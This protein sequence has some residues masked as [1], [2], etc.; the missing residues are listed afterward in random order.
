MRAQIVSALGA[1]TVGL[2]GPHALARSYNPDLSAFYKPPATSGQAG[3]ADVSAFKEWAA[4]LGLATAPKFLG[5]ASTLGSMGFEV[6]LEVGLTTIHSGR[7]YWKKAASDPGNLLVTNQVRI[8]KGLPYSLQISGLVTH[9]LDSD[10]WGIGLEV[11]WAAVEGF[12]YVP[13]IAFQ[14][15]VGTLLGSGDLAMLQVGFGA[16]LSK[17]FN[18]AGLFTVAPYAGYHLLFFNA[19][20]YLTAGRVLPA[21]PTTNPPTPAKVEMFV[22]DGQNIFRHRAVL[23]FNLVATYFTA[24]TEFGLGPGQTTYAFKVGTQF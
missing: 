10:I 15:S 16:I 12:K 20:T 3:T 2:L 11:A 4:E 23:G 21:N 18:V 13:D 24:G 9:L 6:S 19:G 22:I 17:T 8:R 7:D 1:V 14:T 5:P